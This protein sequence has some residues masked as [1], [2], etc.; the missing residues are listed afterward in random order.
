MP[1]ELLAALDELLAAPA[2]LLGTS[3]LALAEPLAVLAACGVGDAELSAPAGGVDGELLPWVAGGPRI[4][5]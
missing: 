2:A 3:L 4:Q 5:T 1:A